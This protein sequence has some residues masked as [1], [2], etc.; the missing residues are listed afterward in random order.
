MSKRLD[1]SYIENENKINAAMV[2]NRK[3]PFAVAISASLAFAVLMMMFQPFLMTLFK[4]DSTTQNNSI[5]TTNST[6]AEAG[7]P[8]WFC[9]DKFGGG[10]NSKSTWEGPLDIKVYP[11][12]GSREVT[13]QEALGAGLAFVTYDGEGEAKDRMFVKGKEKPK[14]GDKVFGSSEAKFDKLFEKNKSKLEKERTL[15]KCLGGVFVPNIANAVMWVS[16]SVTKIAQFTAVMV[17]NGNLI[18]EKPGKGGACLDLIG[19]IGGKGSSDGGIIGVLTSSIYYPLLIIAVAITGL[20]VLKRGLVDR[21]LRESLFGA[22]WMCLS[23]IIGLA[24]LLNPLL[25]TKAPMAVS[26]VVSTCVIGAF[27]GKNC[28]DS[29]GGNSVKYED[30]DSTSEK[31]C[32]SSSDQASINEQMTFTTSS[33]TCSIWRAFI[34]EPYAQGS[35]GTSFNDLD[36]KANPQL[37]KL[38][39]DQGL[40]PNIFCVNL[41]TTKSLDSMN[42]KYIQL[43]STKNK[44][45]NLAAYQMYLKTQATTSGDKNVSDVDYKW[46]RVIMVAAADEGLWA[47]WT[48]TAGSA[49][50]KMTV[51]SISLFA[52][53]L[54]TFII[55]ITSIFALVYYISSILLMAFAPV[56]FLMGV[57]PGRGKR[58]L[59][60]W[61]EKVISNVL[62]YMASAVFLI[63][64]ISIYGGILSS[65]SNIGLTLIFII[66]VTMALFMY[67][68]ELID[69]IGRANMGGEKISS[70]LSEKLGNSTKGA[71]KFAG[72]T[73]VAGAGGVAGAALTSD[74]MKVSNPFKKG[75]FEELRKNS[76]ELRK[77]MS[78]GFKD[79]IKRET[80]R[81][82]GFIGNVARQYDRNT[83]DNKQDLRSKRDRAAEAEEAAEKAYNEKRDD[84]QE[85]LDR[86]SKFNFDSNADKADLKSL[87]DSHEN[88]KNVE[89]KTLNDFR[90]KADRNYAQE[91][92]RIDRSDMLDEDRIKHLNN[93][94][95][96]RDESHNFAQLQE[97]VNAMRDNKIQL[98]VAVRTGNVDEQNRLKSEIN[99]QQSQAGELR[100]KISERNYNRFTR[101]YGNA[102]NTQRDI[103]AIDTL[104]DDMKND[105]ATKRAAALTYEDRRNEIA[106]QL[107]YAENELSEAEARLDKESLASKLYD[108]K[109]IGHRPG[110]GLNDKKVNKIEKELKQH[111]NVYNDRRDREIAANQEKYEKTVNGENESQSSNS[112][113]GSSRGSNNENY[114]DKNDVDLVEKQ[115]IRQIVTPPKPSSSPTN[116]LP[117]K[118]S[119]APTNHIPNK[120]TKAPTNHLPPKPTKE[121]DAHKI[122]PKPTNLPSAP[123]GQDA[124]NVR[125]AEARINKDDSFSRKDSSKSNFE[126]KLSNKE[127]DKGSGKGGNGN[128]GSNSLADIA[129]RRE[130]IRNKNNP[131]SRPDDNGSGNGN[132]F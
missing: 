68:S 50:N 14:P 72:S 113:S 82:P 56:F 51:S 98:D 13:I 92:Q 76:S 31:V 39:K 100:S 36:V 115:D 131:S 80:K 40:D 7:E 124:D 128:R 111:Q 74:G 118:P 37:N 106:Q 108:E 62:K 78:A 70:S 90:G 94:A 25:I 45:C 104:D 75:G 105:L 99:S 38:I 41:A 20:W 8:G 112:S 1:S 101:E 125:R 34:L 103:G 77:D 29:S 23:V 114:F 120:P 53:G 10:M 15:G 28:F 88:I 26:N 18:C 121:P 61:L 123:R 86:Q 63:V 6:L 81:N 97:L 122:P 47:N 60:G 52:S 4:N 130:E 48:N 93:I 46:Y 127:N 11:E 9:S 5:V 59:L 30:G 110:E 57:H 54:G 3:A 42:G 55:F 17:F 16:S 58:I 66:I 12:K 35:F 102:M 69:L 107:N 85:V 84:Y 64:T 109:Y 33:I 71:L 24:L 49:F 19:I 132:K 22:L 73:A 2:N 21:K 65:I 43:N 126:N 129:K 89:N 44:V 27:N 117:D 87:E 116:H 79:G 95:I 67:R 91:K 96:Q 119:S 83:V 32:R